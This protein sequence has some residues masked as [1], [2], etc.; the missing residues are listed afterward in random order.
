M[1]ETQQILI[2]TEEKKIYAEKMDEQIAI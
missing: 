2:E 1:N